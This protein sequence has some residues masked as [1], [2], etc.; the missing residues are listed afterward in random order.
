M[1]ISIQGN[2][3]QYSDLLKSFFVNGKDVRFATTYELENEKTG[4]SKTFKFDHST[5]SEWDV[6]TKW[7]YK[8]E[9]EFVL[10]V[11][12]EEVTKQMMEDYISAKIR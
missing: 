6:K 11:G 10:E 2:N 12:N 4:K 8:S 3:I 1:K 7:I 9:D 5:G